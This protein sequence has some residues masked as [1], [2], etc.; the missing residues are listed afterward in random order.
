MASQ[1]LVGPVGNAPPG[2]NVSQQGGPHGDAYVSELHGKWATAARQGRLFHGSSAAA[3]IAIPLYTATTQALCLWNT[4]TNVDLEIVKYSLGYVS[5]TTV[6]GPIMYALLN[7]GYA[8]GTG[9][10]IAT[11]TNAPTYMR[12][13]RAGTGLSQAQFANV[14]VTTTA[15]LPV[16]QMIGSS[17]STPDALT[18]ASTTIATMVI[19]E[20]FDGSI[21]VP[22]GWAL[23]PVALLASVTLY[24]QRLVWIE[25]P[26][27]QSAGI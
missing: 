26:I 9:S 19:E 18:A 10:P 2:A 16:A 21:I 20:N 12:P 6:A 22:P 3:G 14:T 1:Y 13:G 5:G 4:S 15:A 17:I 23:F 24:Q 27:S 25:N 7:A 8:Y 11:F